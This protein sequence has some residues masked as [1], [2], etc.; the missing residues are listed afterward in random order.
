M[1][2]GEAAV[3]D[4]PEKSG[5]EMLKPTPS[6]SQ[7]LQGSFKTSVQ[8]IDSDSYTLKP[9]SMHQ[10]KPSV[11]FKLSEKQT[12][13]ENL[14]Y[15]LVGK[16]SHGRPKF[17]IIK[18]FFAGLKLQ[19]QYNVS[20]FD[21]K[22]IFIELALKVDYIRIWMKLIWFIQHFPLRIFRWDVDFSPNKESVFA[23]VW[24]RIE[25]LPL[26]LFDAAS[27]WSIAN[28]IGKPL[29][30]D[31]YNLSR[32]KLNSAR[33]C[34]ELNVTA[35]LVDSIWITFE[36]DASKAILDG[37]WVKVVYDVVPQYCSGCSHIGH[38]VEVCKRLKKGALYDQFAQK[39]GEAR[40]A[41]Q[42]FD[43]L[44]Q[45]AHNAHQVF[46]R[47]PQPGHNALYGVQSAVHYGK[48]LGRKEMVS[49]VWKA[50][51]H[52]SDA[53]ASE[54]RREVDNQP[55]IGDARDN[56]H[57]QIAAHVVGPLLVQNSY[58]TQLEDKTEQLTIAKEIPFEPISLV[59]DQVLDNLPQRGKSPKSAQS[60]V[61]SFP[62]N[63]KAESFQEVSQLEEESVE[64]KVF[65][66]LTQSSPQ[67]DPPLGNSDENINLNNEMQPFGSPKVT[68]ITAMEGNK[69]EPHVIFAE[70]QF[71]VQNKSQEQGIGNETTSTPLVDIEKL[72]CKEN[73]TLALELDN[74]ASKMDSQVK[75]FLKY[76]DDLKKKIDNAD[77]TTI[78]R[79]ASSPS[80]K[81]F[82]KTQ[83]KHR[84]FSPLSMADLVEQVDSQDSYY[85]HSKNVKGVGDIG[86]EPPV[87]VLPKLCYEQV[88]K[89][90]TW[91]S[92][93]QIAHLRE[94]PGI[95]KTALLQLKDKTRIPTRGQGL[96]F[97]DNG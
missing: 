56:V 24:I 82:L 58:N 32:T 34:V 79:I 67:S 50:K 85:E 86:N 40:N 19:G 72:S 74:N 29:R 26:Y 41:H 27:L 7:V 97:D 87:T 43:R 17:S 39:G 35:P 71:D 1:A 53:L 3:K 14:N 21:N 10:G 23:P 38:A 8:G 63:G 90:K 12:L 75:C 36:D 16:L 62:L 46:D 60:E 30:I 49:N 65:D 64:A 22:H 76:V 11:L 83:V 80:T 70:V 69:G 61:H 81:A 6:F 84:T 93:V 9:I 57:H 78:S 47:L 54:E 89:Q 33:V 48:R 95:V 2:D 4:P 55:T 31:P 92:T 45:P 73:K 37:F 18:E 59:A 66:K 94:G 13:V 5:A 77:S 20:L 91:S 96:P 68:Q 25:G 51:Q 52:V 88:S 44:S 42:V 28:A 15:V